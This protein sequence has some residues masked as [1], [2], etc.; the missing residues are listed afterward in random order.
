M[1]KVILYRLLTCSVLNPRQ[2]LP[3]LCKKTR[4]KVSAWWTPN[5]NMI[6]AWNSQCLKALKSEVQRHLVMGYSKSVRSPHKG[7]RSMPRVHQPR[8]PWPK[9]KWK[10]SFG[11]SNWGSCAGQTRDKVHLCRKIPFKTLSIRL[12]DVKVKA[13]RAMMKS[14]HQ[15][16]ALFSMS[17]LFSGLSM[18]RKCVSED[19]EPGETSVAGQ[20]P[21]EIDTLKYVQAILSTR[22]RRKNT[23][24]IILRHTNSRCLHLAW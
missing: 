15:S 5:S 7:M 13:T 19:L 17:G 10:Q 2:T 22:I 6:S 4:S 14:N 1:G 23:Y 3:N 9:T 20:K 18:L 16:E 24:C 8:W 12:D 11:P 21:I